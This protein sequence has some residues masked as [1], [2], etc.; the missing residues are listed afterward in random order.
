MPA[1]ILLFYKSI[2]NIKPYVVAGMCILR[3]NV[4]QAYDQVIVH[5]SDAKLGG[6][7]K[8]QQQ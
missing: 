7:S 8:T 1:G 3:A 5:N 2:S 6:A 4:S